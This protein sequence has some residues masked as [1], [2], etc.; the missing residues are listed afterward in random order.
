METPEL[1]DV[2][3][4]AIQTFSTFLKRALDI[5]I[6][7]SGVLMLSPVF[8]VVALLIK[9]EDGGKVFFSQ[10]RHGLNKR[11][12]TI[13]K[14]RSMRE[15]KGCN[16]GKVVQAQRKDGRVTKIGRVIRKTSIDELPQLL[17]V[18]KGDM[19]LVGPRPHAI[20]HNIEYENKIETYA[21][22]YAVKPGIT[23]WAQ[24]Q[25]YRGETET[26]EKMEKRIEMD[27]WYINNKSFFL[28]LWIIFITPFSLFVNE[29]Y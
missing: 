29:A 4:N 1:Q 6:S 2:D 9:L 22:R 18:L 23:G 5:F 17:N 12:F 15:M 10:Q 20:E 26:L 13:Y 27:L 28:D 19:S 24:V 14:F 7:I 25:G 11:C 3:N 21:L 8:I 16:G